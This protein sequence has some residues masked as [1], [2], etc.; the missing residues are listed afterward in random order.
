MSANHIARATARFTE[1]VH[2][3]K[4]AQLAN[5]TPCT[6]YDV[7]ALLNHL[8]FWGP[9]LVGAARK[10]LVPPPAAGE[11]EVDLTDDWA[12][13]LA[14]Y[15]QRLAAAWGEPG[16][17]AGVTHMGGPMELP[18]ELVGGMVAGE[19]V[20][21]GWDL[22]RATGQRPEW[23]EDLA[24]YAHD[25]VA[26]SVELGREMGIYGA[27]VTVAAEAFTMDKLLA[28]SGRDPAWTAG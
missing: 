7:R 16:A 6:D 25:E 8:L 21:H 1:I 11:S 5:P 14:A 15:A 12:T 18:A 4:P 24:V 20:V 3:V 28:L 27:E 26:R 17:W 2:N 22:A 23:D 9:S 19:I 13:A 10:E